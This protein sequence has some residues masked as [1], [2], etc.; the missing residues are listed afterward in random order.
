VSDPVGQTKSVLLMD[1]GQTIYVRAYNG[2][3][4]WE[5]EQGRVGYEPAQYWFQFG[6]YA[7]MV[8]PLPPETMAM[9]GVGCNVVGQLTER[10]HS[11]EIEPGLYKA[12][13]IKFTFVDTHPFPHIVERYKDSVV[14]MDGLEWL[15]QQPEDSIDYV[16]VDPYPV[17]TADIDPRFLTEEFN[18]AIRC[19]KSWSIAL[20]MIDSNMNNW[21][22]AQVFL[23]DWRMQTFKAFRSHFM[24]FFRRKH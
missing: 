17:G 19:A 6:Y 13:P 18:Q 22:K 12:P 16:C 15:K 5:N 7:F 14:Q 9:I 1:N 3:T 11:E 8:P 4:S 23:K 2:M 10:V 24:P 20:L 21:G